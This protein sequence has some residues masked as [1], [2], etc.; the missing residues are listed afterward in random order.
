MRLRMQVIAVVLVYVEKLGKHIEI[1]SVSVI[2]WVLIVGGT[3][4]IMLQS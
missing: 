4:H 1:P 2:E 3:S